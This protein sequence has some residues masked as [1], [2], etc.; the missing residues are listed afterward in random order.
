MN[1]LVLHRVARGEPQAW[2][3]VSLP[4]FDAL[5][6]HLGEG[7]LEVTTV[8]RGTGGSRPAIC[9]SFDDGWRSD[10]ELVFPRLLERGVRATFFITT[11]WVGRADH[12]SWAQLRE[13]AEAGMEIGSHSVTHPHL[14]TLPRAEAERE[15]VDSKCRL[16]QALGSAV[17]AFAYPYGDCSPRTHRQ[18]GAAGYRSI[19]T[20]R[21]GFAVWGART[22]PRNSVNRHHG[23]GE[24]A[25][26]VAPPAGERFRRQAHYWFRESLKRTLGHTGYV[27][28]RD[29]LY[30]RG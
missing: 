16:E 10:Y 20:S 26:L 15:L 30:R 21:P 3:D 2:A 19:C 22:Y 18:A 25:T 11:D 17:T 29:T 5:L 13:M 12:V 24:L 28:L 9:L 23:L 4:M 27:W 1:V 8:G 14:A 7:G 6:D